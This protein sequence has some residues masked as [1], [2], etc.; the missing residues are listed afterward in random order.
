MHDELDIF[1]MGGLKKVM[2]WTYIY[3][4]L[5]SLALCGIWPLAGFYSKD[6]ILEVA[7][8]EHTYIIW[9]VLWLTAG[10]TA[11]YSFRLV[12]LTFW[13]DERYKEFNFHP[14]EVQKY[15]LWGMLPLGVLAVIFGWFKEDFV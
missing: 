3:M 14:H 9:F 6:T 13:S 8:N 7:F 11:F 1:K 12:F 10:M 4:G 5:A 15:V 2:R